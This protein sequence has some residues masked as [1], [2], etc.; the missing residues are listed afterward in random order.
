MDKLKNFYGN[1][2]ATEENARMEYKIKV[3]NKKI[4]HERVLLENKGAL[5][6]NSIGKII[7]AGPGDCHRSKHQI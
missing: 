7:W 3:E 4:H 1:Y 2:R 5:F 6:T